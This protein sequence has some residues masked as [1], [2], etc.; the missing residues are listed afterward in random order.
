MFRKFTV[1]GYVE[2]QCDFG[3]RLSSSGFTN[4]CSVRAS[5][6]KYEEAEEIF[7]EG[8]ADTSL[9]IYGAQMIIYDRSALKYLD[10]FLYQPESDSFLRFTSEMWGSKELADYGAFTGGRFYVYDATV[11][12]VS[13]ESILLSQFPLGGLQNEE[14]N[15]VLTVCNIFI[16]YF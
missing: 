10:V 7:R 3:K 1:D 12:I 14:G 16:E 5:K 9:I 15:L 2:Y 8:G 13:K 4:Y 11:Q 6:E